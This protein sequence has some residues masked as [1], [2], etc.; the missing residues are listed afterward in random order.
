MIQRALKLSAALG[1]AALAL[2]ACGSS[3]TATTTPTNSAT[4]AASAAT[5]AADA[6][7][8]TVW[9]DA[10]REPV[11]KPIA[12]TF[13]AD[14]GVTVNLVVKDFGKI[15]DDFIAQ[16]PT[17][18]G[19]DA[20]ITA[21]D[22][23]GR[24]VESGVV[25]PLELGDVTAQMQEIAIN[26][27][28]YNGKVY[29]VPY[30][31]ENIALLR[32]TDLAPTAP[33]TYDEMITM[34]KAAK[35]KYS[36][37]IG[38]DPK[39]ADPYHTYPFQASFG[40]PV[41]ESDASGYT[42]KLGMGGDNGATFAKWLAAQGKAGIFNLNITGDIAKDQFTKKQSPFFITGP[43]NLEAIQK[44]G[45]NYSIDPIPSAGGEAATPFVGVQG[46]MMS[47]QSKNP[48][49]TQSFLVD[50]LSTEAAQTALFE[51]GDR[52]PANKAAFE[53]A[54]TNKDVAAFGAVGAAGVPMPNVPA[55]GTVWADW[56][57]TQVQIISGKASD[58]AAA[59]AKMVTTIQGK[60]K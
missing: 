33:K 45:I 57:A 6:G 55:M 18:K 39:G 51:A 11:L 36:F 8:I 48:V 42:T 30:A 13:K 34:G 31:L 25:A 47:A 29:G 22:G 24:L 5:S 43:W 26:A 32:N 35:T 17:G 28:T 40:A 1:V 3:D 46:F 19:P 16:A 54:K 56:G 41:F 37:L 44:A 58:P 2:T 14:T 27:F 50:Y 49:A 4:T 52:A 10:N 9:V 12:A 60:I 7:S 38:L 21:H 53:A 59:W 20:V 15:A 23:T